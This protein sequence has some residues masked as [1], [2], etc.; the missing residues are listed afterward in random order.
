MKL[1]VAVRNVIL[2]DLLLVVNNESEQV[3]PTEP[4]LASLAQFFYILS[5]MFLKPI[6][7][8]SEPNL[9]PTEPIANL[10]L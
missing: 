6:C 8:R 3:I 4:K 9:L 2:T 10:P 1:A 7:M 5:I